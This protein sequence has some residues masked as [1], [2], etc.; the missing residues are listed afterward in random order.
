MLGAWYSPQY[1]A[2]KTEKSTK[3]TPKVK[4]SGN[5]QTSKNS[6][7]HY[8]GDFPLITKNSPVTIGAWNVAISLRQFFDGVKSIFDNW[9]SIREMAFIFRNL[10]NKMHTPHR[11]SF[12][13]DLFGII[14][15][16]E[17]RYCASV[18]R[19]CIS[20][21]RRHVIDFVPIFIDFMMMMLPWSKEIM[22]NNTIVASSY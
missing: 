17:K 11:I 1:R 13:N 10:S 18:S 22:K 14:L 6:C 21:S 20:S 3:T 12:F 7:T 8:D 2:Q 19:W 9:I 4:A 5:N 15:S 16:K